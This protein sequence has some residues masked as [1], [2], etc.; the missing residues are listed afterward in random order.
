MDED[1][2]EKYGVWKKEQHATCA[3]KK[4]EFEGIQYYRHVLFI[5]R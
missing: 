5:L 3:C 1:E 2:I 4:F